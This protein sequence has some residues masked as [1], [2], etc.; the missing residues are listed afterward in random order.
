MKDNAEKILTSAPNPPSSQGFQM[1]AEWS[2]HDATWLAWPHNQETWPGK[3]LAKVEEIYLQMLEALLAN[4][5][6]HLLVEDE[7]QG[8]AVLKRLQKMGI[9]TKNLIPHPVPTA[10]AWIRD[11][12]PTFLT[13]RKGGK[14]W[15][16]W[17][18]NAWGE[19]Y[20][21]LKEDRGVFER[22]A[23]LIPHPCFRAEIVLEGGSVEVNGA[24][25][26]LVTE[27]CLLNP[28]RN[29]R[30]SRLDIE[31][32]LRD[33]LGVSQIIWL[34]KGIVGDDTDGHIDDIARFVSSDTILVGFEENEPDENSS[35]LRGNWER[36]KAAEDL[37]QRKW[38]LVKLPMPGPVV[39]EG[40]RLPASYANFYIANE[41][42]LLPVFK[43]SHDKRA[44]KILKEVFFR[45]EVIPID[46]RA[47]V[48]GLGALH[49]VTQQEPA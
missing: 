6:V 4:E 39:G 34:G 40:V 48:Y 16:K 15:C 17:I 44:V 37:K 10:D 24:G 23:S 41:V 27:Q 2:P 25:T 31:Q 20:E 35:I 3:R 12:G 38:N 8:E 7:G 29:P 26:C 49:C 43:H 22:A 9:G 14:A 13:D 42:V 36:L 28:N 18:F 21:N 32:C 19:K 47:L 30:L 5:K 1:P 11:Y 46:C 33:F 45:R